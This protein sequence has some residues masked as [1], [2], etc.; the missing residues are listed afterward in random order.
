MPPGEVTNSFNPV[1]LTGPAFCALIDTGNGPQPPGSTCGW[2][3][4]NLVAAG[5]APDGIDTVVIS[6]CH[7]DH[8]LGLLDPQGR[9]AFP[10]ARVLVPGVEWRFW[11]DDAELARAP[12]G[13]MAGLFDSNRRILGAVAVGIASCRCGTAITARCASSPGGTCPAR[14]LRGG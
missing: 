2:L 6:H 3:R 7:G 9:P 13:R 12:A 11:M 5:I 4:E 1:V 8:V 14:H 10:G